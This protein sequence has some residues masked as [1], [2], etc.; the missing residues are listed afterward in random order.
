[1]YI[2][3]FLPFCVIRCITH[4]PQRVDQ[5]NFNLT[6]SEKMKLCAPPA[7]AGWEPPLISN[8]SLNFL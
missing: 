6:T 1:M 2:D 8:R 7:I 5:N 3:A 4:K